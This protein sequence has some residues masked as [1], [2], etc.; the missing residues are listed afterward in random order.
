M[1]K[2]LT[3]GGFQ[4]GSFCCNAEMQCLNHRFLRL[5]GEET[6]SA[7]GVLK[8][9]PVKICKTC[10]YWSMEKKGF[11]HHDNQG[12]GQFWHCEH[13]LAPGPEVEKIK[14]EIP[15]QACAT[16]RH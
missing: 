4:K 10:R 14:A 7:T 8:G 12:V 15:C 5:D 13:W 3:S 6:D 1:S 2:R 9:R 16:R 11:C